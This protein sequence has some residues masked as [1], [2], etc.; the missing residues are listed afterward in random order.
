M[1]TTSTIIGSDLFP[2]RKR[3]LLGSISTAI[4][5]IG[6]ASGGPLGGIL[7]DWLGWRSAFMLQ[8]SF[9]SPSPSSSSPFL[10]PLS[11][12]P[13]RSRLQRRN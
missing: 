8:V 10:P 1:N 11:I 6:G 2:L 3:G 9:S 7:S 4:W 5:A 12:S 13:H